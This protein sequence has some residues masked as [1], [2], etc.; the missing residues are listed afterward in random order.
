MV[1][2]VPADLSKTG[3][4]QQWIFD[5]GYSTDLA[6]RLRQ[7]ASSAAPCDEFSSDSNSERLR[8]NGLHDYFIRVQR[9]LGLNGY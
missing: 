3:F 6:D 9:I 4:E 1:F 2:T 5:A 8:Y 7:S